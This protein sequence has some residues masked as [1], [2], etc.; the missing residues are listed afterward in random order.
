MGEANCENLLKAPLNV[1]TL[2]LII[3]KVRHINL[4]VETR[5]NLEIYKK[6]VTVPTV[7]NTLSNECKRSRS[8]KK[9]NEGE[10]KSLEKEKVKT[11]F[12]EALNE[13]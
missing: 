3:F 12:R 2:L 8:I 9:L 10:Y 6:D 4:I 13:P 11:S 7:F 5:C 1:Q